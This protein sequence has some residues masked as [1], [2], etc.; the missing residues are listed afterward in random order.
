MTVSYG[1]S[2]IDEK[3]E[4][5]VR[6]VLDAGLVERIAQVDPGETALKGVVQ[7]LV[8][9]I[10]E[11]DRFDNMRERMKQRA[12]MMRTIRERLVETMPLVQTKLNRQCPGPGGPDGGRRCSAGFRA[13]WELP[14]GE[15]YCK[16]DGEARRSSLIE[17]ALAEAHGEKLTFYV[18]R[19]MTPE[20]AVAI[21]ETLGVDVGAPIPVL[22]NA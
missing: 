10:H 7:A 13:A 16:R 12:A 3:L 1:R 22:D 2:A 20:Q 15:A 6:D 14:N 8:D 4:P 5:A 11:L 21:A 9:V 17:A 18:E 19:E